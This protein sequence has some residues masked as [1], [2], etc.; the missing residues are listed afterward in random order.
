[1]YSAKFSRHLDFVE[2]YFF[3][4]G[5]SMHRRWLYSWNKF[6]EGLLTLENSKFLPIKLYY[7]IN[8][9]ASEWCSCDLIN[10]L[11]AESSTGTAVANDLEVTRYYCKTALSYNGMDLIQ[12]FSF[13]VNTFSLRWQL[14]IKMSIYSA[15]YDYVEIHE[16]AS[17]TNKLLP[18]VLLELFFTYDPRHARDIIAQKLKNILG[19]TISG[20]KWVLVH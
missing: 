3:F 10:L 6:R 11:Q 13:V 1:M 18:S 12:V 5:M 14:F 8:S 7:D 2:V 16:G 19:T 4:G 17:C 15:Y 20:A 9:A